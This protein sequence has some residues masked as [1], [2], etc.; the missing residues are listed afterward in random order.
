[1][2]ND[3]SKIKTPDGV[4]HDL[5]DSRVPANAKF[6][7]TNYYHTTGSWNGL[8]YTATANGGAGALALTLPTGTTS[9]TVARGDHTHN[10]LPL[11]GGTLTGTLSMQGTD[12]Q[13]KTPSSSS[14]DSA[15]LVWYYGNSQEKMRLW[16]DDIYTAKS[17]PN[18]RMYNKSGSALYNGK[19]PLAD[20]TS[21]SGTWG[22]SITGN[23]ATATTATKLANTS[24]IGDANRPVYFTS[25]GVP[26]PINKS[27]AELAYTHNRLFTTNPFAGDRGSSSLYIS[28]IDNGLYRASDRYDVTATI[29]GTAQ[30][31]SQIASLFDG[32]YETFMRINNGQTAVITIDTTNKPWQGTYPYGTIYL[33]FYHVCKPTS[34]SCRIYNTYSSQGAGWH[35]VECTKI[36][37]GTSTHMYSIPQNY[38]QPKKI[39]I[40]IVGDTTNEYGYTALTQIE[41]WL[42]RPSPQY[43]PFVNKYY[44]ETLYSSLTAPEF[45]ENGTSLASKYAAASHT[46]S[47]LPLSGGALTGDVTLA[48]GKT[49]R[50]AAATN[51]CSLGTSSYKWNNAHLNNLTV[52]SSLSLSF[53]SSGILTYDT[54]SGEVDSLAFGASTAGYLRADGVW[55]NPSN[56]TYS[57]GTGLSLSGTTFNH[58]N[59]VRAVTTAGLYKV[60]YDAQGHITGTTAV[61]KAD[62]TALGIPGSNTTYS[63]GTGLTLSSTTFSVTSANVSTIINLLDIGTSNA[64]RNDYTIMQY[65]GGGT[66]NSTYY[67][68]KLSNVFAALNSSDI[69]TALGYTPYNSTNPNGY[70]SNAGTV[71]RIISGTGLTGGPITSTG[72]LSVMGLPENTALGGEKQPI[73]WDHENGFVA[74][75]S[76]GASAYHADSYFAAA[77][78]AHGNITSAGAVTATATIASGDRIL[79][80]DSSAS[81]K[82]CASGITFGTGTGTFLN[83]KGEWGTPGG[84]NAGH[85]HT[86]KITT[87][88]GTNVTD[89]QSNTT[90]KL[91]V[92]N[93]SYQFKT[94]TDYTC[95][96]E[97]TKIL[98]ADNSEKNIEDV[99][100]GDIIMS[101][102]PNTEK[103]CEA[104]IIDNIHTGRSDDYVNYYFDD[105]SFL[106]IFGK[107]CIYSA[108]E[109]TAR[110]VDYW[111]PGWKTIAADGKEVM[112]I[113]SE[114][115]HNAGRKRHFDLHS[116]NK[117]YFANGI[118][119]AQ[120]LTLDYPMYKDDGFPEEYIAA[121]KADFDSS[122]NLHTHQFDKKT[123]SILAP[124]LKELKAQKKVMDDNKKRLADSDYL[125]A[126]FTEGLIS[127]AEWLK[128][129]AERAGWRSAVNKAEPLYAAAE[130]RYNAFKAKYKAPNT[131]RERFNAAVARDNACLDALKAYY[132][133]KNELS[134]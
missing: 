118:L 35:D 78:H 111:E 4:V 113:G 40:T 12:I 83:N 107:H 45:I 94:P 104:V 56:A 41:M 68:R 33:S 52:Y 25:D 123:G 102:D 57:A 117:L 96:A 24:A 1:M 81:S 86:L 84:T 105:G 67:R 23:A 13:L 20:G 98:M 32:S 43:T 100:A 114:N 97:G 88:Q 99:V 59:S 54:D 51:S 39:E 38:Y 128:A 30:S 63:A 115:V 26:T 87:V 132:K 125:V 121:L 2:A 16:S 129:K 8:T 37:D 85:T 76:I 9:T 90:Y 53:L 122:A 93:A 101:Y 72:T 64:T 18:F 44:P 126:K 50:P 17:G 69:T 80:T 112:Y 46:H 133:S 110:G 119:N 42:Q 71:T 55:A 34:V 124:I 95:L 109:G 49:I 82:V 58:S 92:G 89:L 60:K 91:V 21:A 7:D 116:S 11:S 120:S 65:S 134:K 130:E 74:G 79:I 6:T 106:S 28:K 103:L 131:K 14:N 77:S 62:I 22:I 3:I 31:A 75:T 5:K 15:D 47:Y 48:T 10:Y 127:A 19:L 108:D 61:A 36:V 27:L 29:G 70:T 73:Y 66:S